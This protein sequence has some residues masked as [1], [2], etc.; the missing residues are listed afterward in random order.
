MSKNGFDNK[1]IILNREITSNKTKY[2]E[3]LKKLNSL[4]AKDNT[5]LVGRTYFTSNGGS[6]NTFVYQ[7]AF[8]ELESKKDKYSHVRSCNSKELHTFKLKSL[9]IAL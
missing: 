3:V 6:Q 5:F 1:L 9:Y 7:S 2:L 8:D 4:T